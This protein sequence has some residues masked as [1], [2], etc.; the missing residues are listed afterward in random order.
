VLEQLDLSFEISEGLFTIHP[1]FSP[2][3]ANVRNKICDQA[4]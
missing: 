4:V 2:L 1:D 3:T